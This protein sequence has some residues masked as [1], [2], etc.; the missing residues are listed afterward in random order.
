MNVELSVVA[1][2]GDNSKQRVFKKFDLKDYAEFTEMLWLSCFDTL[3]LTKEHEQLL[4]KYH[5]L[6]TDILEVHKVDVIKK[7]QEE[8]ENL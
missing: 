2:F 1:T 8:K 3:P 6:M 4:A 7:L 5:D